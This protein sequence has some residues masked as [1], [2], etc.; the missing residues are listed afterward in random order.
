[1]AEGLARLYRELRT[2]GLSEREAAAAVDWEL[3]RRYAGRRL[4]K[5]GVWREPTPTEVE[6]ELARL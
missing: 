1:M 4:R 3:A 5:Q 2:R 6:R